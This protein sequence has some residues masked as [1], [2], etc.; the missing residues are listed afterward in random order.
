VALAVIKWIGIG[1][2][3]AGAIEGVPDEICPILYQ[4]AGSKTTSKGRV[5]IVDS[6]V[7]DTDAEALAGKT[8]GA[9]LIDLGQDVRRPRVCGVGLALVPGWGVVRAGPGDVQLGHAD[10]GDRPQLLD[11]G[12]S[13]NP[14]GRLLVR[15]VH[16]KGHTSEDLGLEIHTLGDG[17]NTCFSLD[18]AEEGGGV[19]RWVRSTCT[20]D[21]AMSG[22]WSSASSTIYAPG[23]FVS[24]KLGAVPSLLAVE[25]QAMVVRAAKAA[26]EALQATMM[27]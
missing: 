16:L 18:L 22:T 26:R 14:V 7:H 17:R 4:T 19:L 1:Y 9:Q 5:G 3:S 8:L 13:G 23:T 27:K 2:G 6:R 15:A 12:Q 20:P 24:S 11:L 10:Q 21:A 25:A